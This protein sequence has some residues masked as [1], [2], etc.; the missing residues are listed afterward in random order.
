MTSRRA[1]TDEYARRVN[2][3]MELLA[4][5][6]PSGGVAQKLARQHGVSVRQG[7]RYVREAADRSEPVE[8]P[9]RKVVFTVKVPEGLVERL[10]AVAASRGQTLSALVTYA[11]EQLLGRLRAERPRGGQKS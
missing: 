1:R 8:V 5:G 7:W 2:Q 9:E 10:R 4:D 6:L 11:L 3:A